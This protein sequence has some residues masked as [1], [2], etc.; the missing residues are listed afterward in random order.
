MDVL[1]RETTFP[2]VRTRS[3]TRQTAPRSAT[4]PQPTGPTATVG[5]TTT[6]ETSAAKCPNRRGPASVRN[7]RSDRLPCLF[8][9]S[10]A[11]ML[12]TVTEYV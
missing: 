1:K 2:G 6:S 5:S 8:P 9:G 7:G 12:R 3:T 10:Y 11:R 4:T